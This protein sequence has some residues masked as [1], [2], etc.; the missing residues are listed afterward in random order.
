[1]IYDTEE[2]MYVLSASPT[3]EDLLQIT[4]FII[5]KQKNNK[6]NSEQAS[7]LYDIIQCI[8]RLDEGFEKRYY[9]NTLIQQMS[10]IIK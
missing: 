8:S 5:Y 7:F 1:M 3:T 6:I 9:C 2:A 4:E 10:Q